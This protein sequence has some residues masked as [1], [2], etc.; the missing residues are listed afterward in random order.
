MRL[1][2]SVKSDVWGR[3]PSTV[4]F[5]THHYVLKTLLITHV[6]YRINTVE[7]VTATLLHSQP[8]GRKEL[9]EPRS[10]IPNRHP[11]I[12]STRSLIGGFDGNPRTLVLHNQSHAASHDF[13][14]LQRVSIQHGAPLPP[15]SSFAHP[16][17]YGKAASAFPTATTRNIIPPP[18]LPNGFLCIAKEGFPA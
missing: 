11:T 5:I 12:P 13:F 8:C 9:R 15:A 17:L 3:G 1:I 18:V 7:R 6:S 16:H 14:N 4:F 10:R 2:Y